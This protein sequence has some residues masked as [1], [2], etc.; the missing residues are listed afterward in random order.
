M[1]GVD[2]EEEQWLQELMAL[3]EQAA[4][5]IQN[6]A[7]LNADGL[8]ADL[9][10]L[11]EANEKLPSI[12]ESV[13]KMR[14]PKR[15]DFRNIKKDFEKVLFTCIKAGESGVKLVDSM[16]HGDWQ[17]TQRMRFTNVVNW[18]QQAA[19]SYESLSKRL[20]SLSTK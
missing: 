9:E 7:K 6:S 15:K 14:K 8:P 18:M 16:A 11:V 5:L 17:I 12:L 20:T 4:P 10:S 3:Y 13:K 1:K 2:K 19:I